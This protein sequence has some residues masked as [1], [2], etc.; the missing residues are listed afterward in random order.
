MDLQQN[1]NTLNPATHARIISQP[2]RIFNAF[3]V[4]HR[5]SHAFIDLFNQN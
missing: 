3:L 4:F 1:Y 5:E 2:Q